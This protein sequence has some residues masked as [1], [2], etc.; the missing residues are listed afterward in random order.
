MRCMEVV[1]GIS[2][3][4]TKV[5]H[6]IAAVMRTMI[7]TRRVL[8]KSEDRYQQAVRILHQYAAGIRH[9]AGPVHGFVVKAAAAGIVISIEQDG[10]I[11]IC[12][13]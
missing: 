13:G 4:P 3:D 10:E 1:M 9:S 5:D 11:W 8:I 2:N 6:A 12:T 7:D